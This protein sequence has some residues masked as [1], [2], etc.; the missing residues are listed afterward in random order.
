[1]GVNHLLMPDPAASARADLPD[2]G[3]DVNRA[4]QAARLDFAFSGQSVS[5]IVSVLLAAMTV[6]ML[7]AAG[8]I[9]LLLSWFVCLASVNAVRLVHTRGYRAAS[10]LGDI[11]LSVWDRRL[12]IG[13]LVGGS[14]WGSSAFLFLP[15]QPELQF[16]LAFVIAGVSSG[17]VSSLSVAPRAAYAFVL[18]CVLPLTLRFMAAGDALH[19]VMG[20]MT[21]FYIIVVTLVARRGHLQLTRMVSSQIEAQSSRDALKSS[22]VSRRLSDE[23]L[24][25]AAEAGHI[26]VWELDLRS[27]RLTW[28]ERMHQMYCIAPAAGSNT[29]DM[30]RLRVM[31]ADLARVESELATAISGNEDFKSEFRIVWPNGEERFIKAA[32]I[33]QRDSQGGALRLT[34]FNLDITELKRLDRIKSEFVSIVSHEL[35]TP[36]TS[37]RGSLGLTINDAAGEVPAG[38]KELLR[39]A[40]RNAERLGALIDDL[41]DVEKLEAGKLRMQMTPQPLQP[42]IEQSLSANTPYAAGHNVKFRLLPACRDAHAAVDGQRL[43]QVMT[44]LLSNAV[45]FS[46]DGGTVDVSITP[47]SNGRVRVTVRDCGPGISP[48]F[49]PRVFSKFSQS[50]SSDS[51]PKGGTGLGLAI[52]KALIEQMG[53]TIGFD[54][55]A[56]NGTTFF[57]ELPPCSNSTL[58]PPAPERTVV[59]PGVFHAK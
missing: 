29:Y 28:D 13:C 2:T 14:I 23:R 21:G 41:L 22:E 43:M 33:A 6:M 44:N 15:E 42:L 55:I 10:I 54:T 50:D 12:L 35:R 20:A 25:V 8:A 56:G 49:Q 9:Q 38:A 5:L 1:M 36:L 32:A 39:V 53:G 3:A 16:F 34:G 51:R 57:F 58:F 26:G 11:D 52:S 30:W 37:I 47:L 24:R 27:Q 18:P 45:K 7:R 46:P 31:P 19:W 48:E 4:V 17:A 40:D 59:G